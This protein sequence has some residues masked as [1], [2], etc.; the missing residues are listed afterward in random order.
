MNMCGMSLLFVIQREGHC[1]LVWMMIH[2]RVYDGK[3]VISN[4]ARLQD[5]QV[6]D[7]PR[8]HP[9]RPHNKL[10]A[11]VFYKAGFIESWGR[12][13]E[14]IIE[15]CLS[16]GLPSP[17]F[18][19]KMG[20]LYLTFINERINE[21]INELSDT[22]ASIYSLLGKAPDMRQADL[23]DQLGLTEQY[24]RKVIKKLKDREL[25]ERAGSRKSG[26]WKIIDK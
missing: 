1:L 3:L 2:I 10:I 22:E 8:P 20:C 18:E 6:E 24:V 12:G 26:Y 9:S 16:E 4:E 19:W 13:T 7:L 21:R 15:Y 25:I 5:I 14:R 23:A 11:D 17:V